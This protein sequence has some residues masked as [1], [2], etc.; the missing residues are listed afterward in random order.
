[1]SSGSRARATATSSRGSSST[2]RSSSPVDLTSESAINSDGLSSSEL[3]SSCTSASGNSLLARLKSP[4]PSDLSRKRRVH[5]NPPPIGKKRCSGQSLHA[6]YVPKKIKPSHRITEF[7]NEK[8]VESAG[9][10]FCRACSETLCLKRSV[11]ASHIKSKK[12]LEGKEN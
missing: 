8:L 2:S 12:H 5:S 7:P 11:I 10:L 6:S 4:T 3:D 1:M 9:Q